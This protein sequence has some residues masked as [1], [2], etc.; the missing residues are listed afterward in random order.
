MIGVT[1]LLLKRVDLS[2]PHFVTNTP[3][4]LQ[5]QFSRLDLSGWMKRIPG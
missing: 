3:C 4:S 1:F 2:G 5:D